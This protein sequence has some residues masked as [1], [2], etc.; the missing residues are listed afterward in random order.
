MPSPSRSIRMDVPQVLAIAASL[1]SCALLAWALC[2]PGTSVFTPTFW[3]TGPAVA[4][5][6]VIHLTLTTLFRPPVPPRLPPIALGDDGR[7]RGHPEAPVIRTEGH[8]SEADERDGGLRLSRDP[9][10]PAGEGRSDVASLSRPTTDSGSATLAPSPISTGNISRSLTAPPLLVGAVQLHACVIV[11]AAVLGLSKLPT[12]ADRPTVLAIVVIGV[13][14]LIGLKLW[15]AQW[16]DATITE[17]TLGRWQDIYPRTAR[18][19]AACGRFVANLIANRTPC[20]SDSHGYVIRGTLALLLTGAGWWPSRTI[21]AEIHHT[22]TT[23]TFLENT[24]RDQVVS[25]SRHVCRL[26]PV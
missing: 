5:G 10:E 14:G 12:T 22:L 7:G 21:T 11:T 3:S 23:L 13:V 1:G 18:F 6:F 20:Q 26:Y 25:H 15:L 8:E 9:Q 4:V 16:N 2:N 19:T 17:G 24:N